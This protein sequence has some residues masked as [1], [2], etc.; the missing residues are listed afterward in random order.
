MDPGLKTPD[1]SFFFSRRKNEFGNFATSRRCPM[2]RPSWD[3]YFLEI[4]ESVSAR[5]DCSRRKVGAVIV[6]SDRRIVGTGYNGA[7]AG[8][9]GCLSGACPRARSNSTPGRDYSNCIAVHAEANALLYS[10]WT[11]RQGGTMYINQP[12]CTEC[13]KLILGSG[14]GRVVFKEG[15]GTVGVWDLKSA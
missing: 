6:S 8:Q 4:A 11:A 13:T 2:S 15:N 14:L 1:P 5:A 12:P 3:E 10:D 7:P 9:P